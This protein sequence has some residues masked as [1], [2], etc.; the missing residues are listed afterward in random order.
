MAQGEWKHIT[1]LIDRAV[2][3]LEREHPMTVRQLFYRLVS[4]KAVENTSLQYQLVSRVMTKA[5]EDDRCPWRY[6]VDRSRQDYARSGWDGLRDYARTIKGAYSKNYWTTQPVLV[7]L[8]CEK[9]AVVGS[10]V[11]L[12]KELGVTLRPSKGFVSTTKIHEVAEYFDGIRKPIFVYYLGDWD[13]SGESMDDDLRKRLSRNLSGVRGSKDDILVRRLAIF[14]EDIAQFNLP[15]LRIKTSDSRAEGFVRKHGKQGVELDALPPTELRRRVRRAVMKH[16][17]KQS[18][19][20]TKQVEKAEQ[21]CVVD[22]CEKL[23]SLEV[24]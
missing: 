15:P 16:V 21:Q 22:F 13:P 6:I 14:K 7:E 10:I 1:Q 5:R 4:C 12:T 18:W 19:K 20:R 3:I 9:D 23:Q 2:E 24:A 8:W 11:E 17:D